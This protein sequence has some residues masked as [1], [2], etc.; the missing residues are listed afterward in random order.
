MSTLRRRNKR[1]VQQAFYLLTE[2][3]FNWKQALLFEKFQAIDKPVS[4]ASINRAKK[5]LPQGDDIL[6][7]LAEGFLII[8]KEELGFLYLEEKE[9]FSEIPYEGWSRRE[10]RTR[11]KT[12]AEKSTTFIYHKEGRLSVQDKA[13]F[14]D[15]AQQEVF[16]L[17][18]RLKQLSVYFLNRN[19]AEYKNYIIEALK[20]GINIHCYMLDPDRQVARMYFE[21]RSLFDRKEKK[22][23]EEMKDVILDLQDVYQEIEAMNLKG[24][25]SL[26]K[27]NH[28]PHNY[29]LIRDPESILGSMRIS[30]YLLG[31]GRSKSPVVAFTKKEDRPLFDLY[32]TSFKYFINDAV[33]VF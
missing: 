10:I 33:R 19:D 4:K 27:Y 5:Q 14:I 20:R 31:V 16:L 11:K 24:K 32:W 13:R 17:G 28:I 8:V 29:F 2:E 21:D 18:V 6:H 9:K 3:K 7:K 15:G 23:I 26:F 1:I 25:L 22:S 12:K 30:H